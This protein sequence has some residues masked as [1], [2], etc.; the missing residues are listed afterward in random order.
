[1]V[2]HGLLSLL[3]GSLSPRQML[4][5]AEAECGI[6]MSLQSWEAGLPSHGAGGRLALLEEQ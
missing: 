6:G 3:K 5:R 1:M 2:S 4:S